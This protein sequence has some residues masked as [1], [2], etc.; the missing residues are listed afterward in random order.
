MCGIKRNPCCRLRDKKMV[1]KIYFL[2]IVILHFLNSLQYS[3]SVINFVKRLCKHYLL[4]LFSAF[5]HFSIRAWEA[6]NA[7]S[8]ANLFNCFSRQELGC[9]VCSFRMN[10]SF[11][12]RE[13]IGQ[14]RLDFPH[15]CTARIL[16]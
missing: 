3:N 8:S 10:A 12:Q 13:I 7:A 11:M 4:H 9:R 2:E 6:L 5:F 14:V 15:G 16:D 1:M